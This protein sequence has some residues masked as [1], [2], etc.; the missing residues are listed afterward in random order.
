MMVDQETGE[1]IY[2]LKNVLVFE[3]IN[4]KLKMINFFKDGEPLVHKMYPEMI[5]YLK[6]YFE[7]TINNIT[8]KTQKIIIFDSPILYIFS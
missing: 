5:K 8:T 7:P 6:E 2:K 4:Q 3:N 1:K